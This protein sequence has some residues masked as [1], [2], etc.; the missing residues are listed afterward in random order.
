MWHRLLY[1]SYRKSGNFEEKNSLLLSQISA[2]SEELEQSKK[3]VRANVTEKNSPTAEVE[4]V[5]NSND[6]DA[7]SESSVKSNT[8]E[9]GSFHEDQNT[10][11]EDETKE[12]KVHLDSNFKNA[13]LDEK[14]D[15]NM[16][17]NCTSLWWQFL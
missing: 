11:M 15:D 8:L 4:S 7:H 10:K 12:R 13:I 6:F 16:Y 2:L 3:A 5:A 14:S 9:N 17:E 1:I